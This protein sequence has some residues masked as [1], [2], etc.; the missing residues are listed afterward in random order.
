MTDGDQVVTDCIAN[1][2]HVWERFGKESLIV[3]T[4]FLND[5][6][7]PEVLEEGYHLLKRLL[8]E[9]RYGTD[10]HCKGVFYWEPE[11]MPGGYQLGAFDSDA[12][13]T[14]VMDAYR[15]YDKE[16]ER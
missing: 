3:E 6:T 13:P 10:G 16:G 8:R 1:I 11:S 9:G 2:K 15:D 7:R 12:K 14:H 4:G 5:P